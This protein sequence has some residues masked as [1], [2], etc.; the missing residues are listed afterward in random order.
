MVKQII[1]KLY[2]RYCI[3]NCDAFF[4]EKKEFTKKELDFMY[5]ECEIMLRT[6]ILQSVVDMVIADSEQNQLY[7]KG[8]H[9]T[10]LYKRQGIEALM[11]KIKALAGKV[12]KEGKE[13]DPHT[14]I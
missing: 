14:A 3:S 1:S 12:P 6:G 2:K 5:K 8:D 9:H 13:F 11:N 7:L 4:I 10:E